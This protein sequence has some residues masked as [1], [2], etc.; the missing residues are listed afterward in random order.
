M[1]KPFGKK[2]N[3]EAQ[4]QSFLKRKAGI[5]ES[6]VQNYL[7]CS[8][9][10]PTDS[11]SSC[12]HRGTCVLQR[13]VQDARATTGLEG[14]R[15]SQTTSLSRASNVCVPPGWRISHLPPPHHPIG[16]GFHWCS[17]CRGGG[18]RLAVGAW[19]PGWESGLNRRKETPERWCT[20][21]NRN[22]GNVG[23]RLDP[24]SSASRSICCPNRTINPL[25][26]PK[27]DKTSSTFKTRT[28]S[29][30]KTREASK[31][32]WFLVNFRTPTHQFM[33]SHIGQF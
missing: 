20:L 9:H 3:I 28:G 10:I 6:A 26:A 32:G 7:L 2:T 21:K 33:P 29:V 14:L 8:L 17:L 23:K 16:G 4:L 22:F 1:E 30:R 5:D 15:E 13:V 31:T 11:T 18:W 19:I 25:Q 24:K 12:R 27:Q